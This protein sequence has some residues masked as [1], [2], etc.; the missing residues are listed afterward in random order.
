M[1]VNDAGAFQIDVCT[2][3]FDRSTVAEQQRQQ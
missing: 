3:M 2:A 1:G